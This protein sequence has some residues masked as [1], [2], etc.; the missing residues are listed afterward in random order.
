MFPQL[1]RHLYRHIQILL[2]CFRHSVPCRSPC[3]AEDNDGECSTFL[4]DSDTNADPFFSSLFQPLLVLGMYGVRGS[5][6]HLRFVALCIIFIAQ[7][8]NIFYAIFLFVP[9]LSPLLF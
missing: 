7:V 4:E 6:N 1:H 5:Q 8:S 3:H 9:N 2:P